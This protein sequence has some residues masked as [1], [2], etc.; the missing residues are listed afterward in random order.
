MSKLEERIHR[1]LTEIGQQAAFSPTAWDEIQRRIEVEADGA[2]VTLDLAAGADSPDASRRWPLLAVAAVAVVLIGVSLERTTNTTRETVVAFEGAQDQPIPPAQDQ[3]VVWSPDSSGPGLFATSKMQPGFVVSIGE[4]WVSND[5]ETIDSWSV[6][7][8]DAEHPALSRAVLWVVDV[9]AT[10]PQDY[11][12]DARAR[13]FSFSD[14][15][16]AE[17]GGV[18]GQRYDLL[19]GALDLLRGTAG[20]WVR[21]NPPIDTVRVTV[22]DLDGRVVVVQELTPSEPPEDV[23]AS[24]GR[25]AEIVDQITWLEP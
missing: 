14:P 2:V 13:G 23:T 12:Q 16:P 11:L 6:R 25:M 15:T 18:P 21:V 4:G 17:I 22:L 19:G 10:S 8:P 7:L 9:D 5:V 24:L 20:Q 1:G 3:P